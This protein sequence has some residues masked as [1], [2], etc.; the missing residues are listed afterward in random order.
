M[1]D[2]NSN[3]NGQLKNKPL[4]TLETIDIIRDLLLIILVPVFFYI[5]AEKMDFMENILI[6]RTFISLIVLVFCLL[7]FIY[8]RIKELQKEISRRKKIESNLSES[9]K[10]LRLFFENDLRFLKQF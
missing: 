8:R 7:W 9:E 2:L 6:D 10:R 4:L 5:F 1:N 3:G